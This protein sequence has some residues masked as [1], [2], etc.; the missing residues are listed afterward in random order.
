[1]DS[2][3]PIADAYSTS[4]TNTD[5]S[6]T[7]LSSPTMLSITIPSVGAIPIVCTTLGLCG[8]RL[9]LPKPVAGSVRATLTITIQPIILRVIA[10][11]FCVATTLIPPRC[12]LGL[13]AFHTSSTPTVARSSMSTATMARAATAATAGCAGPAP[14]PSPR[15]PLTLLAAAPAPPAPPAAAAAA[16]PA[17]AP[18][19]A[20]PAPA[21]LDVSSRAVL[22]GLFSI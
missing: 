13:I 1:M 5:I 21:A 12:A 17:P 7:L 15:G 14:P 6:S 4:I 2:V 11:A 9:P 10:N 19:P 18:A 3:P 8:G 16:G 20:G 22:S